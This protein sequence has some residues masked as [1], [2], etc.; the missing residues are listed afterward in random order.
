MEYRYKALFII[1]LI[2]VS[3]FVFYVTTEMSSA[4]LTIIIALLLVVPVS[5]STLTRVTKG[6]AL[7]LA[8]IVTM[9]INAIWLFGTG[10][11]QGTDG[12]V[13][14]SRSRE[15]FL[16]ESTQNL[17]Q[18]SGSISELNPL[19]YI[20]TSISTQ[21][22]ELPIHTFLLV[23]TP[24]LS[25]SILLIY[26]T[27]VKRIFDRNHAQIAV[28]LL[29]C[30]FAFISFGNE[31]RTSL[32]ATPIALLSFLSGLAL[33]D[34]S[35]YRSRWVLLLVISI[36][37][38]TLTHIVVTLHVA[39]ISIIAIIAVFIS[40][41]ISDNYSM[42][43][44]YNMTFL[45]II[46]LASITLYITGILPEIV[47]RIWMTF[48]TFA[49]VLSH[50]S[51]GN[52]PTGDTGGASTGT[53][54]GPV[55]FLT[56]WLWRGLFIAAALTLLVSAL[57][58]LQMRI[59][60][61]LDLFLLAGAGIYLTI[62]VLLQL[63][64]DPTIN[65][66]RVYR[67]FEYFAAII[68]SRVIIFANNRQSLFPRYRQSVLTILL[69]ILFIGALT[70]HPIWTMDTGLREGGEQPYADYGEAEVAVARFAAHYL[71]PETPIYGG[72]WNWRL[73]RAYG[74]HDPIS[75]SLIPPDDPRITELESVYFT[76]RHNNNQ[77]VD[78]EREFISKSQKIYDSGQVSFNRS[79]GNQFTG[80]TT[81]QA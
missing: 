11:I 56:V 69:V 79:P 38:L 70:A 62:S 45:S 40:Y 1:T 21:T 31:I 13:H 78:Y 35:Y 8:I 50:L 58:A 20:L 24:L 41:K 60:R 6:T 15:F 12:P 54:A 23:F 34:D 76:V 22:T 37:S 18:S 32:M 64:G 29:L 49:D 17:L 9:T 52:L 44:P 75:I 74:E 26:H 67:Y 33:I 55:V 51:S 59:V 36:I 53:G 71:T 27:L 3:N 7:G 46:L 81:R 61:V 39:I 30:S 14:V 16:P 80:N 66:G 57:R 2:G 48:L 77:Y 4:L 43:W 47:L 68:F 42:N 63:S 28:L 19:L 72:G 73:F 5:I 25:V 10:Y 65:P